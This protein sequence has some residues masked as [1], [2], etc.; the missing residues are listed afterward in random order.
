MLELEKFCTERSQ[1]E[2]EVKLRKRRG[3]MLAGFAGDYLANICIKA[4]E[5]DASWKEAE[6]TQEQRK[7]FPALMKESVSIEM[8]NEPHFKTSLEKETL[9][10]MMRLGTEYVEGVRSAWKPSNMSFLLPTYKS[11]GEE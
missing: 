10:L 1:H 4:A 7:S 2:S 11:V 5:K 3:A 6:A 9:S 8:P